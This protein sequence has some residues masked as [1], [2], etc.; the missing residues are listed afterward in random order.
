MRCGPASWPDRT[1]EDQ[2]LDRHHEQLRVALAQMLTHPRDRAPRAHSPP[3][4][5]RRDPREPLDLGARGAPVDLG[6]GRVREL[7]GQERVCL[8]RHR[9]RGLDRLAHAAEGLGDVHPC[10]IQPQQ[11]LAL[12]AHPLRKREHQ[13]IALGGAHE[14]ERDAGVAAGRLDDPRAAGLDQ[15]F[16]L[17]C[18]D[19]RHA[20]AI[21]D[22][23]AGIERLELGVQLDTIRRRRRVVEHPRKPDQRGA[24]DEFR[25]VDRDLGHRPATIVARR[26]SC[27]SGRLPR[28]DR[29]RAA[30]RAP[31]GRLTGCSP[32]GCFATPAAGL[33]DRACASASH[34]AGG[35][36]GDREFVAIGRLCGDGVSG[37]AVGRPAQVRL[38]WAGESGS[39]V[40]TCAVRSSSHCRI[41]RCC[42]SRSPPPSSRPCEQAP[43]PARQL[44]WCPGSRTP[45]RQ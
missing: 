38:A 10:A 8:A 4:T 16:G 11:A 6:V 44:P 17:G 13:L 3:P 20:D 14:R 15:A 26:R 29:R 41:R 31:A 2:R 36:P 32:A 24:P 23:P 28:S 18:L 7:I 27:R 25:N 21:L 34:F 33:C 43:S 45:E 22:A 5:C 35:G 39:S 40:R 19:H 1:A 9:T 37:L 12:A 30:D 42:R